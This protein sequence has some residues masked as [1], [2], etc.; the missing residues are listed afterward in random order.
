MLRAVA[1]LLV[2]TRGALASCPCVE[3]GAW[4]YQGGSYSYC[5]NPNTARTSWCPKAVNADGTYTSDLP[6]AYCEGA[7][8]DSCEALK[9]AAAP[10]CP[11]VEGGEWK[12][13]GKPQSYCSDPTNA[14]FTWCA[15]AVDSSGNFKNDYAICEGTVKDQCDALKEAAPLPECPCLA[16]G[17]WTFDGEPQSYCQKPIGRAKWCPTS[18]PTVTK[19]GMGAVDVKYCEGRVLDACKVLEGTKSVSS[20]PCVAGGQWSHRGNSYSYCEEKN[21]CPTELNDAGE[22]MGKFSR[23]KGVKKVACHALHLLTTDAGKAEKF[24]P[25]TDASAGATCPCW[26]DLNRSDCACCTDEGVQCGA[27]MHQWCTSRAEGR[28]KGCPG[29]PQHH[30]TLSNTGYP[31][32]FNSTRTDCGW[33]AAGGAQCGEGPKLGQCRDPTDNGYCTAA[34]GDC[35]RIHGCDSQAT[36]EFDVKFGS[37]TEH[38]Q[39]QCGQGWVG[40]GVQCYD[41]ST[42]ASSPELPAGSSSGDVSLTLAVTNQYYVYPHDSAQFP[43]AE[44]ETELL[45]NITALFDSGA[46][47][48]S[49]DSCNGTFVTLEEGPQP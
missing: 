34:P 15:T 14:G 44:G 40:N 3:G 45:D 32:F 4:S 22:F 7:A 47:C 17:Q 33:C 28:Q 19:A 26:F 35:L 48:A 21:W 12:Y 1:S 42:G 24:G 36:C 5:S 38:H 46:S 10:S 8:L 39:C 20:C 49:R 43:T 16:G 30:W 27:P 41:S 18:N 11:C 6:F 2:V 37:D 13:R 29:V 25:Y 9:E 23:C 31:C